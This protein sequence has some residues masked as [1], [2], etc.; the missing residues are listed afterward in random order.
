MPKASV[1]FKKNLSSQNCKT[2]KNN[3]DEYGQK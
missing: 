1:K 2:S 3:C